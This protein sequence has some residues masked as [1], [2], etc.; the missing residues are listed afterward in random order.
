VRAR[1]PEV[2]AAL[3]WLGAQQDARG[4]RLQARLTGTGACLFAAFEQEQDAQRVAA[5]VPERWRGI[6]ARGLQC[7]PLHG[8]LAGRP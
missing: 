4:A 3:D 7:S 8:M 6:L 1:Y 2:A 5:R